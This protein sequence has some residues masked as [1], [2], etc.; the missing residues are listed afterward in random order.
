MNKL[1]VFTIKAAMP[2]DEGDLGVLSEAIDLLRAVGMAGSVDVEVISGSFDDL[3][4]DW[5]N[6]RKE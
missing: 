1:L 6:D 5:P 4:D 3:P 2:V